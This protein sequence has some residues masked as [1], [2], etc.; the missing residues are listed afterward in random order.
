MRIRSHDLGAA[1]LLTG[2]TKNLGREKAMKKALIGIAIVLVLV[3]LG[4]IWILSSLDDIVK[5]QIEV[6]GTE[7]TGT[8]VGVGGVSIKLT[9]GTGQI[10]GLTVA[11]P[12]GYKTDDA[13][14][15]KLLQLGIDLPSVGKS[16]LI[17]NELVIDSPLVTMEMNEKGGSNLQEISDNVSANTSAA[18]KEAS[19]AQQEAGGEPLRI[20]IRKLIIKDVSYAIHSPV[21]KLD[22]ATGTLPTI[23]L[24]NVGGN[25]GGTPGEI[26][27]VIIGDLAKRVIKQAA[28]AGIKSA[29]KSKLQ[30]AGGGLGDALKKLGN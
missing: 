23:T 13:F 7:L 21:E 18:D 26:G 10:T 30:D 12:K 6:I 28:E 3:V 4:V 9:E 2:M 20:L 1:C 24:T 8:Q 25:N 22:N 14:S 29:V 17:L 27:K 5:N 11:S 15:M 16:P 19:K